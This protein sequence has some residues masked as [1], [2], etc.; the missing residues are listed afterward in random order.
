MTVHPSSVMLLQLRQT[1][2]NMCTACKMEQ[3]RLNRFYL[4]GIGK[5]EGRHR[6][7]HTHGYFLLLPFCHRP[8][9]VIPFFLLKPIT[10]Y[11]YP[12]YI[13]SAFRVKNTEKICISKDQLSHSQSISEVSKSSFSPSSPSV[14]NQVIFCSY[15]SYKATTDNALI[16]C[17][18]STFAVTCYN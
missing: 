10:T 9:R 15:I 16:F 1:G 6:H 18:S 3:G 8:F 2:V 11:C 5:G 14:R 17:V 7:P 12:A 13:T 4:Y